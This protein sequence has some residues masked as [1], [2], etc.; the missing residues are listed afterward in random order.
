[1]PEPVAERSRLRLTPQRPERP[2]AVRRPFLLAALGVMSSWSIG[3][4]FLSLGPQLSASLFHT[5]NHLV[6]GLGVFALA[7]SARGRAARVRAHARRGPAPPPDR[8]RSPRAW[9]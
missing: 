3:G 1:M 7:G 4:L 9:C 2:A 5:T 6:A 8:S